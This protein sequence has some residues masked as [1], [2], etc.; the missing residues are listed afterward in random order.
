MGI[1]FLDKLGIEDKSRLT[2]RTEHFEHV[3]WPVGSIVERSGSKLEKSQ[4]SPG[5][6]EAG[7]PQLKMERV[8]G[9]CQIEW[10]CQ[11]LISILG[12][13]DCSLWHRCW[14][15]RMSCRTTSSNLDHD[16]CRYQWACW[17]C[18]SW[19]A[20]CLNH[21]NSS[22]SD[23]TCP[24]WFHCCHSFQS[25]PF[26]SKW[27]VTKKKLALER[28]SKLES[29]KPKDKLPVRWWSFHW[30]TPL[31]LLPPC[32]CYKCCLACWTSLRPPE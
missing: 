11:H 2:T 15:G 26:F 12:L 24:R 3:K 6:V 19:Q 7:R 9:S 16:W 22:H 29:K 20:G 28:L 21:R 1:C 8:V 27:S 30:C 5:E 17:A 4:I 31:N 14:W 13:A 25:L 10:E 32:K 23:E 18:W